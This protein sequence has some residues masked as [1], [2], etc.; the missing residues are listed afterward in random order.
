MS[1]YYRIDP[2][3]SGIALFT[4]VFSLIMLGTMC[5]LGEWAGAIAFI[6]IFGV[7]ARMLA[8][9]GGRIKIDELG[10][11]AIF[12]NKKRSVLWQELKEV[13]VI[14]ADPFKPHNSK[15]T[16]SRYL[17][18]FPEMLSDQ[19]KFKLAL[20]W[21]PKDYLYLAYTKERLEVVRRFWQQ[22]VGSYNGGNLNWE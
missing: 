11:H 8:I 20:E 2:V 5:Y 9:Y 17:C 3:K 7:F 22:E 13:T 21:P 10:V 18:F 15:R 16:G 1:I 6:L 4:C 14:G 12:L 19:E